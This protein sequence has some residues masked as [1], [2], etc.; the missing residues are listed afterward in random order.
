MANITTNSFA[1]V[2]AIG[3]IIVVKRNSA[4]L[5]PTNAVVRNQFPVLQ[6]REVGMRKFVF[7]DISPSFTPHP[8]TGDVAYVTDFS[9]VSQSIKNIVMTNKN[10]RH[11]SQLDFGVGVDR[12]LFQ[13]MT[14]ELETNIHDDIVFQITAFEPRAIL[15]EVIVKA[16]PTRHAIDITIKYGVKTQKHV[17]EIKLFIERA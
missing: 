10:E 15:Y 12:Y 13:P 3:D 7:R 14:T 16:I 5:P 1:N 4:P 9:A 6:A 11:F 17:E 8:I 2:S